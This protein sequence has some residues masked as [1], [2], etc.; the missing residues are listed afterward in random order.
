MELS[1]TIVCCKIIIIIIVIIIIIIII[2]IIKWHKLE[3]I[4]FPYRTGVFC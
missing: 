4:K 3:V 1:I 2:I